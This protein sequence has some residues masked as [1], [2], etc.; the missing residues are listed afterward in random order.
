MRSRGSEDPTH[1]FS[2][3]Y[4]TCRSTLRSRGVRIDVITDFRMIGDIV[5]ALSKPYLTPDLA[6]LSND[7]TPGNCLWVTAHKDGDLV[8][9]VGCR[10]DDLRHMPLSEFWRN[11]FARHHR[12]EELPVPVTVNPRIDQLIWGKVVYMGDLI[13]QSG[14]FIDLTNFALA[15]Q[16]LC[17]L[18][19]D[20]DFSYAFLKRKSGRIETRAHYGFMRTALNTHRWHDPKYP[21]SNVEL[22]AYSAREDLLMVAED[23]VGGS[24]S[25]E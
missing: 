12:T 18:K 13:Y 22:C 19:W 14:S 6:P 21:R 5:D 20:P 7:F 15:T 24:S 11:S 9:A 8:G 25:M 2:E 23:V 10:H 3:A 1:L 16:M 17:A 4:A